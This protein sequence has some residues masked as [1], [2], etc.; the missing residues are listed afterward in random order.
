MTVDHPIR[1]LLARVCSS[2]TMARVVDPTLADMRVEGHH[3]R[4]YAALVRALALHTVM[5][6]PGA[7]ARMW[8]DDERALPRAIAACVTITL[9]VSAPLIAIPAHEAHFSWYA[10]LMLAPQALALA[11]PASLLVAVPLA[12]RQASNRRRILVRGLALSA[13]CAAATFALITRA[14][15]DANQAFRVEVMKKIAPRE[16]HLPRG[17]MEM[18]LHELREQIDA[19]RLT[20]GGARVARRLEY[21]YQVKLALSAIALPLGLLAAAVTIAARGRWRPLLGGVGG[22][23]GYVVLM[24]TLD[25]LAE[26]LITR[27]AT[28]PAAAIAWMPAAAIAA[29]GAAILLRTQRRRPDHPWA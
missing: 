19:L 29:A 21:A 10:G 26:R 12:S 18:T 7:M 16:V 4:G 6:A 23:I 20:P 25:G 1:R 27:S 28:V 8:S 5:S 9:V 14:I 3:W 22:T 11:L 17:P 15:P 13:L 2:D 24:F